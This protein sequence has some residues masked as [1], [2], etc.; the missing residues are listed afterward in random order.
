MSWREEGELIFDIGCGTGDVTSDI[1]AARTK[2]YT[3]S[4]S[5]LGVDISPKM[6]QFAKEKYIGSFSILSRFHCS[7]YHYSLTQIYGT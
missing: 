5:L 4:P 1:L 3:V 2:E 7:V 6:V